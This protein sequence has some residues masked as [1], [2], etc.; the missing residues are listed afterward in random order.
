GAFEQLRDRFLGIWKRVR[1]DVRERPVGPLPPPA[2]EPDLEG[3]SRRDLLDAGVEGRWGLIQLAVEQEVGRHLPVRF[4]YIEARGQYG[5][6]LC[7]E[8]P[9]VLAVVH[10]EGLHTEAVP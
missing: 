9:G 4:S 2:I 10:E 3:A 1:L 5:L 7:G 6:H 8:E